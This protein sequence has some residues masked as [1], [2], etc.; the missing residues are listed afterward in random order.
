MRKRYF[1]TE[2]HKSN[3]RGGRLDLL[4]KRFGR[5]VV[6]GAAPDKIDKKSGKHKSQWYCNCDCGTKGKIVVGT[7]LTSGAIKSCGCLH[8]EAASKQLKE[9]KARTSKKRN[10]YDLTGD[11]GI[12]YAI[13]DNEFYFDLEDYNKIKDY[14]W[15]INS[16]GYVIAYDKETKGNIKMHRLINEPSDYQVV[17]H[18]NGCKY[19]NRKENLR[20]TSQ[21]N[22][23]KNSA[24]AK[25]NKSGH[26]GV[27]LVKNKKWAAYIMCDGKQITLGYFDT[28]ED[29]V[30]AREKAEEEYFGEFR[31]IS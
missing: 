21:A 26:T 11:F 27:Y 29:A 17:D 16:K 30:K 7:A 14:C 5:L 20:N 24:I 12:G 31:R 6:V 15:H 28:Y 22:N 19:D 13:H 23:T 25:N 4:G 18:I 3:T 2:D 8:S 1:V 10:E 9:Y